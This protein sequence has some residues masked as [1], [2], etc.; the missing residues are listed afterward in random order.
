MLLGVQ[1][2]EGHSDDIIKAIW[3]VE[4]GVGIHPAL[5]SY[6]PNRQDISNNLQLPGL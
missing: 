2:N 4:V 6:V 1:R 3:V 5:Q